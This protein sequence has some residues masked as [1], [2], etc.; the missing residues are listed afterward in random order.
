MSYHCNVIKFARVKFCFL[1]RLGLGGYQMLAEAKDSGF[2]PIN[3]TYRYWKLLE[4]LH[5]PKHLIAIDGS[6]PVFGQKLSSLNIH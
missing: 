1:N 2:K 6:V 3:I 5:K 4:R